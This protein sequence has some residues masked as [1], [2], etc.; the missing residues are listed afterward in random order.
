MT[1]F[2]LLL[3]G[4]LAISI[5]FAVI[6]GAVREF[7]TLAAL[8]GGGLITYALFGPILGALGLQGS[9]F[10]MVGVAVGLAAIFFV[11][12]YTGFHFGLRYIELTPALAR[13][14]RI[15]GGVFGF[16]R[17][18]A[19][20]G[21]SF[22]GYAYY[23]DED[24]RPDAV[25]QAMLLPFAQSAA[26]FFEG[27]APTYDSRRIISPDEISD[28]DQDDNDEQAAAGGGSNAAE[29]G[30]ARGDRA[31][32]REILTTSTTTTEAPGEPGDDQRRAADAAPDDGDPI[33]DLLLAERG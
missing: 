12:L 23:L 30:Y 24:R 6:R 15:G 16:L 2:D 9:F 7:A 33:A 5:G 28:P 17:G 18:F 25:N 14:D 11:V 4:V 19:L 31:A 21:L 10:G 32:L 22:L 13:A 20:I 3:F 1:W 26:G 29:G 8:A 27:L